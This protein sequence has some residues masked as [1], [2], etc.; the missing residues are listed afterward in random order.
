VRHQDKRARPPEIC[1]QFQSAVGNPRGKALL[2]NAPQRLEFLVPEVSQGKFHGLIVIAEPGRSGPHRV[3]AQ[4]ETIP[5]EWGHPEGLQSLNFSSPLNPVILSAE[6]GLAC[7]SALGVEDLLFCGVGER[8]GTEAAGCPWAD[9]R[10]LD[11]ARED[12]VEEE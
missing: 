4:F 10:S 12:R 6:N 9:S 8:P 3:V 1:G 11:F 2:V 7:E 5:L